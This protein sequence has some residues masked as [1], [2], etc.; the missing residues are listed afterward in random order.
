[1]YKHSFINKYMKSICFVYEMEAILGNE[2]GIKKR[3]ENEIG[4]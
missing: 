4:K 1:M 3:R 2:I